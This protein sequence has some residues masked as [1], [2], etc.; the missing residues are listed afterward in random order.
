MF[1]E[2]HTGKPAA[3]AGSLLS[4]SKNVEVSDAKLR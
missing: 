4:L 1:F 2:Q 3:C